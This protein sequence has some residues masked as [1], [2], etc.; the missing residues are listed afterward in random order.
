VLW[1]S[2]FHLLWL[3]PASFVAGFFSIA[4]PFS[5]L[6]IPGRFFGRLCCIGLDPGEIARNTN[7]QQ[8]FEALVMKG[9]PVEE[10]QRLVLE[11]ESPG[12]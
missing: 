4:F 6:S 10:A 12:V 11:E 9:V 8:R 1:V 2:P 5:L 3:F 7:R